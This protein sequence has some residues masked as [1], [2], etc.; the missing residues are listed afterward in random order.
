MPLAQQA[1]E[2]HRD[3]V[4]RFRAV[5]TGNLA[6]AGTT[7]TIPVPRNVADGQLLIMVVSLRGGSGVTGFACTGWTSLLS[8]NQSTNVQLNVL[9]RLAASE[10]ASYAPTWTG[11]NL[12]VGTIMAISGW[13]G[14]APTITSQANT[15][16]P[17]AAT[18]PTITPSRSPSL[19]LMITG[20]SAG[21][22]L[23]TA[24]PALTKRID[25]K[26]TA[27]ASNTALAIADEAIRYQAAT[28]TR[29]MAMSG[30]GNNIGAAVSINR[31][32]A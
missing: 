4:P 15:G 16:S 31:P 3:N 17:S 25:A 11:S 29:T 14:V 23:F 8:S 2:L 9:Y 20:V 13:D 27:G 28:G 6:A 18:A 26:S 5:D 32:V 10:P 1:I 21:I 30:T 19:L 7:L 12:A 24:N 22:T